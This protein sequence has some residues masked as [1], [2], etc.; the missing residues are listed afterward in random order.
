[1]PVARRARPDAL[2]ITAG[3]GFGQGECPDA[4]GPQC[5]RE[6]ARAL[7][8]GTQF[9]D[10][11]DR[12]VLVR[13]NACRYAG[14]DSGQFFVVDAGRQDVAPAAAERLRVIRCEVTCIAQQR[15]D[16]G[17]EDAFALP[18]RRGLGQARQ[19]K[20]PE[21]RAEFDMRRL[22]QG[23]GREPHLLARG[24]HVVVGGH[25]WVRID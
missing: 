21:V 6:V 12:Q 7:I 19:D 22:Q 24:I 10:G 13:E 11:A 25:G 4:L 15:V 23:I 9:Q 5:W 20:T 17:R 18:A 14:R 3:V 1:M 16:L 8:V 2:D